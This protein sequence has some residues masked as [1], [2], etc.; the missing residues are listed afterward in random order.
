MANINSFIH[1]T[2][3]NEKNSFPHLLDAIGPSVLNESDLIE[4]SK[5]FIHSFIHY[6]F[7]SETQSI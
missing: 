5:Y 2:E 4:Q 6:M 7:I 3:L 1:N